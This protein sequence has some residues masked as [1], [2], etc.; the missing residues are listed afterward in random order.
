MDGKDLLYRICYKG[1]TSLSAPEVAEF[2]YSY[3][4]NMEAENPPKRQ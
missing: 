4:L 1:L 3:S 2:A